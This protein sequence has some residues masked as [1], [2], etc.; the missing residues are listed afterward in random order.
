MILDS[1]LAQLLSV[2]VRPLNPYG[3]WALALRP[4][5]TTGLPVR[6]AGGKT[7]CSISIDMPINHTNNHYCERSHIIYSTLCPVNQSRR[8][9]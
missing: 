5:V 8:I 1:G 3:Q 4:C 9:A 6:G 7:T 2:T